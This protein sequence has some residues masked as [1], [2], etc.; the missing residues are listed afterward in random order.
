MRRLQI[1]HLTEYQFA[2]PVTLQEHRLLL[3]PREGHDLRIE[4]SRLDISPRCSVR[5]HR[6]VFDNSVATV[7]FLEPAQRLAVVSEVVIQHYD[8]EPLDFIVDD[9]AVTYPFDYA[10]EEAVD[11]A[12]FRRLVYPDDADVL[13]TWATNHGFD[14]REVQTYVLLD[15]INRVIAGEFAYLVREEPGV[16]SPAKTLAMRSGSCRDF[17]TLFME[18][19]R[20]LGL[21]AR[22]ISG[23]LHAPASEAGNASTHA[24]VEVYLPGPGWKG[25]DSTTG[26]VTGST[27]IPVAVARRPDAVPPVSGSFVGPTGTLPVLIVN[28]RVSAL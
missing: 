26:A 10:G 27:H 16:Q 17:A 4:S 6:D 18:T 9:H 13:R 5:W 7:S 1:F 20:A 3:R 14:H 12:P 2:G 28:V 19:C 21:A 22:F 25:F 23:Y 24:W 11:L 8:E 15:R